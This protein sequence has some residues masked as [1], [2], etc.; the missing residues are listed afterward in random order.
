MQRQQPPAA[1]R[2]AAISAFLN[3]QAEDVAVQLPRPQRYRDESSIQLSD[4][5]RR[6]EQY[7]YSKGDEERQLFHEWDRTVDDGVLAWHFYFCKNLESLLYMTSLIYNL[8][9]LSPM[10]PISANSISS[11]RF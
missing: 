8:S 10:Q 2:H 9:H 3:G 1:Y 5:T 11:P 4:A 7:Q 6:G